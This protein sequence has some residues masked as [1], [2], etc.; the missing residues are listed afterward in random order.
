MAKQYI[1]IITNHAC[2]MLLHAMNLWPDIITADFWT[3]A[4]KHAIWLHN[5]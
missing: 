5:M 4:V 2:T 1:G 3:F